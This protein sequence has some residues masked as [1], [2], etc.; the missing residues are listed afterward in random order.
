MSCALVK[1]KGYGK[2]TKHAIKEYKNGG[3]AHLSI[4]LK[5]AGCI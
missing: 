3:K 4:L 2:V 1:S 5:V